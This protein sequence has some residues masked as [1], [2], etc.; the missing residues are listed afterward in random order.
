MVQKEAPGGHQA[1][2]FLRD[3]NSKHGGGGGGA[4][5]TDLLLTELRHLDGL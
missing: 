1:L 2:M 3:L 5:G 4:G